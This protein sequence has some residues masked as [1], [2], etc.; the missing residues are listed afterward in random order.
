MAEELLNIDKNLIKRGIEIPSNRRLELDILKFVAIVGM[1]ICHSVIMLCAH[2]EGYEQDTEFFIADVIFGEYFAVAHAFMFAMGVGIIYSKKNKP[3]DLVKRG[4]LFYVGGYI[5]NFFRYGIYA[6]VDGLI[7][8]QFS[9][10]TVYAL[11]VQDIFHFAGIA[12]IFTGAMKALKLKEWHIFIMGIV[13][14]IVG[15]FLAFTVSKHTIINYMLG[16]FIVTTEDE[17]TFAF[18]N[19]YIFVAFGLFF[20]YLLKNSS[21]IDKIYRITFFISVPIMVLYILL[22]CVF[23]VKFMTKENLYYATSFPETIGY[24]SI[25]MSLLSS[26][27]ITNKMCWFSPKFLCWFFPIKKTMFRC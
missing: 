27:L 3:I 17:S 13:F 26:L 4:I 20:G 12:M 16:H 7:E 10:Y 1:I 19:W 8:G 23:G 5:L 21:Q 11:V 18:F 22:S 15:G 2:H 6:L 9:D 24:L 25:D 14:S